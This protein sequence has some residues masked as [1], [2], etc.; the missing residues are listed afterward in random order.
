M[1]EFYLLVKSARVIGHATATSIPELLF[2]NKF[3]ILRTSSTEYVNHIKRVQNHALRQ[4]FYKLS[5][6]KVIPGT[7]ITF[8]W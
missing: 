5:Q 4:F 7:K 3:K 1:Y 2:N 6:T 8:S